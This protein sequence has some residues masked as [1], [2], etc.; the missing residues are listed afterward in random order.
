MMA[1]Y[2]VVGR[3]NI[4]ETTLTKYFEKNKNDDSAKTLTYVEFP[5]S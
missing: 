3:D 5:T 1:F 4:H 2:Y